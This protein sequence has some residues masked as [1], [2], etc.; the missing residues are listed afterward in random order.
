MS[1][2]GKA[3]IPFQAPSGVPIVG[4]PF[5]I[6]RFA[7][8]MNLQLRCNCT[9]DPA[10]EPLEI[11]GSVAVACP[12][13]RKVYNAIFNPQTKNIEMQVATPAPEQV[14]A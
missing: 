4:Q 8:P 10:R 5:E 1:G 7:V 2:N 12:C 3:P 13:C 11:R 9:T 14:P 6:L